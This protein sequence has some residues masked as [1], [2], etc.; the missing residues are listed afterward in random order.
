MIDKQK[1]IDDIVEN[2]NWEK[3]HKTM[4]ALEWTWHDSEGETPSVG[5]L[6]NLAVRLLHD[7]YDGAEREKVNYTH[8]TGGFYARAFVDDETK[9]IFELRLSFEV[10]S[11]EYYDE[12]PD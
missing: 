2:F 11:W 5:A 9:E 1:A 3:V 8:A 7:A 10:C 12:L 6:F 4:E